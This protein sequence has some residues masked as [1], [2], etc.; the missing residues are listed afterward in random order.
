MRISFL[1]RAK[2]PIW[3][4]PRL[5]PWCDVRFLTFEGVTRHGD[6]VTFPGRGCHQGVT[7]SPVRILY[8]GHNLPARA[9]PG[10]AVEQEPDR[11]GGYFALARPKP[12]PRSQ[13]SPVPARSPPSAAG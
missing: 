4:S 7:A 6:G 11:P 10:V 5:Q 3:V 2:P 8:Y 1:P 13:P 12:A 9:P